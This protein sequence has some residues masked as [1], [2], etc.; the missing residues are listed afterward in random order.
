MNAD[1]K[2]KGSTSLCVHVYKV[3]VSL[4]SWFQLRVTLAK[5]PSPVCL[6]VEL[7]EVSIFADCLFQPSVN[8]TKGF[9][10]GSVH[11]I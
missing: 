10:K 5:C 8:S 3:Y 7:E 4:N 2:T 6:P 11:S 1:V 9:F